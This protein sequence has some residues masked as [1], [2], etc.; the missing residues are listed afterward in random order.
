[1]NR[2]DDPALREHDHDDHDHDRDDHDHD[3]DKDDDHE[4]PSSV[5]GRFSH[6]LSEIFGAHFHDSAE[7]VDQ[8]LE[9]SDQG[10]RAVLISLVILALTAALQGVVVVLSGSV[11]LLGDTLHNVAVRLPRSRC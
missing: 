10:R 4:H 6:G 8:T 1:M 2:V 7:Q 5:W 3:D 11:A 9:A